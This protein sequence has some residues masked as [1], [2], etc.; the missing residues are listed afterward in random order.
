MRHIQT[1][2]GRDVECR[3]IMVFDQ[4]NTGLPVSLWN[5][6]TV[7]RAENWRPRETGIVLFFRDYMKCF[8]L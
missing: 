8:S 6:E 5:I 1:K 7:Y 4:T 2:D 3:D